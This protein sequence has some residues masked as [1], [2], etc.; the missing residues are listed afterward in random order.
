MF[1]IGTIILGQMGEFGVSQGYLYEM[2]VIVGCLAALTWFL[3]RE[4]IKR[5][6]SGNERKTYLTKKN[7]KD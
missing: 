3:H 1:F 4:N 6:L 5:L 7:K 2:Y